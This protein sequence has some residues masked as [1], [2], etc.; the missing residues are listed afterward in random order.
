MNNN[1]YAE[2]WST[3]SLD[4][5]ADYIFYTFLIISFIAGLWPVTVLLFL[6]KNKIADYMKKN[7]QKYEEQYKQSSKDRGDINPP[8]HTVVIDHN[9][10]NVPPTSPVQTG[11]LY[12]S[13]I[14]VVVFLVL[15]LISLLYFFFLR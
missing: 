1:K 14:V 4:E 13:I 8:K 2:F 15:L 5:K 11:N 9:P 12:R 6:S 10:N 3:K 7:I